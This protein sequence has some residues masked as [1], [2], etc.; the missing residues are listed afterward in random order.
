MS[1]CFC[2]TFGLRE[3]LGGIGS[4]SLNI[5]VEGALHFVWIISRRV[6]SNQFF[7]GPPV[8]VY[9]S[10]HATRHCFSTTTYGVSIVTYP[11]LVV[12]R[13][14]AKN[15][16]KQTRGINTKGRSREFVMSSLHNRGTAGQVSLGIRRKTLLEQTRGIDTKGKS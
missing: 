7:F 13:L 11:L 5:Q 6:C 9:F 15:L 2:S 14:R 1:L 3:G 8:I 12:K 4:F 10:G 16:L